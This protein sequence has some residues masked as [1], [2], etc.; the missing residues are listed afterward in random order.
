MK[1]DNIERLF[2]NKFKEPSLD[3]ADWLNPSDAIFEQA[4]ASYKEDEDNKKPFIWRLVASGVFLALIAAGAMFWWSD[5][6]NFSDIQPIV[7]KVIDIDKKAP[8]ADV[9]SSDVSDTQDD[10]VTTLPEEAFIKAKATTTE[11]SKSQVEQ[12]QQKE[13]VDASQPAIVSTGLNTQQNSTTPTTTFDAFNNSSLQG[14]LNSDKTSPNGSKDIV[15]NSIGNNIGKGN[16]TSDYVGPLKS[17]NAGG[18]AVSNANTTESVYDDISVLPIL[19]I[20]ALQRVD[21]QAPVLEQAVIVVDNGEKFIRSKSISIYGGRNYSSISHNADDFRH[22]MELGGNQELQGGWSFGAGFRTDLNS[23]WTLVGGLSFNRINMQSWTKSSSTFNSS[24]AS[25]NAGR[26]VFNTDVGFVSPTTGFIDNAEF[27]IEDVAI[28]NGDLFDHS[29]EV[30]QD[31]SIITANVGIGRSL[32]RSN[33]FAL[34]TELSIGFDYIS[35][36]QENLNLEVKFEDALVYQKQA[37]WVNHNGINRIGANIGLNIRAEWSLS[38]RFSLFVSPSY[39]RS[40]TSIK[41]NEIIQTRSFYNL[42]NLNTGFAVRF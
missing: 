12:I 32:V 8:T 11:V 21:I 39:R 42:Y 9:V 29:M 38:D 3:D 6:E 17:S 22:L 23:K 28:E 31:I 14:T 25:V 4:L 33:K 40:L 34:S 27:V 19:S 15:S 18:L 20:A 13:I 16:I 1:N 35:R 37:D 2:R 26:R 36:I 24:F 7:S 5:S 30:N 41:D 10:R